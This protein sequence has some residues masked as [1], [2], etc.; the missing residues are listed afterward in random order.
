MKS[1]AGAP[2][3]FLK[4]VWL[5]PLI[6]LVQPAVAATSTDDLQMTNLAG[7]YLAARTADAEKDMA[8]ASQFFRDAYQVDP[9]NTYLLERALILT[10]ASGDVAASFRLADDLIGKAPETRA[11]HLIAAVSRIKDKRYP[12]AIKELD[13]SGTGV[14]AD[15]TNG[16][17]GAWAYLGEGEVDKALDRVGALKGEEWYGPFKFLHSGYIALAAGRT[18]AALQAFAKAHQLDSNAV[19]VSQAYATALALAGRKDEAQ[20]VLNDFLNRYPD[21]ALARNTLDAITAGNKP[22]GGVGTPAQG[23][24]EVLAGIGTAVGEEGGL[25]LSALYLQLALNLEPQTG[26]GVAALSLGNILDTNGQSESAITALQ[27][28]DANAPFRALGILRAA[29]ALDRLDRTEEA[30]KAFQEAVQRNPNDIQARIAYGNMLRG[31]ERF[32]DSAKLYSEAIDR[33]GVPKRGDWTLFYFR[34]ISYERTHDWPKAEADFKKALELYPDQ[35]LVLNYLGYSWVDKG[36]NFD[37]ALDMIKKAVELRPSDGYVVDSLGWAY[38]RLGRY[39]EA[40][41]QLEKAI[42]LRSDDPVINDHLGDAYWRV[43]RTL[44]SQFQWRHSR[45]FG[46]KSPDLDVIVKKIAEGRLIDAPPPMKAEIDGSA[47]APAPSN[48]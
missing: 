12:E 45:D 38:Y 32:A 10:A 3:P 47:P 17:L 27:S 40:V 44:E 37:Q 9:D 30:E 43:G 7:T 1:I 26:G 22:D 6:A 16:L 29:I 2:R 48:L 18:D 11:A 42:A 33:I 34:G 8:R 4:A 41:T 35:P 31:R 46:A 23:A 28:I 14:L 15:L 24:A 13:L 5:L 21:N 25:E 19:R 36:M 20:K 39:D